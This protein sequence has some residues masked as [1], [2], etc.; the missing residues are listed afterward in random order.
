MEVVYGLFSWHTL[1]SGNF[2][3]GMRHPSDEEITRRGWMKTA[4]D[5]ARGLFN[6]ISFWRKVLGRLWEQDCLMPASVFS[7]TSQ[8]SITP[9]WHTTTY[10]I[11]SLKIE[12][13][14]SHKK[15]IWHINWNPFWPGMRF[16]RWVWI[17]RD[18]MPPIMTV[19]HFRAARWRRVQ[20]RSN[21]RISIKLGALLLQ[22]ALA[23]TIP[24]TSLWQNTTKK[25]W[26]Q[27]DQ[28][29][30]GCTSST[31]G[32]LALTNTTRSV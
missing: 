14:L 13:L 4:S 6:C 12:F 32:R 8:P 1:K 17:G 23:T 26:I 31:T 5:G 20:F 18:K 30:T 7:A 28:Y 9:A 3:S 21:D 19:W 29:K 2:E 22:L 24:V 27:R 16:P 10:P 25:I 11:T 15:T